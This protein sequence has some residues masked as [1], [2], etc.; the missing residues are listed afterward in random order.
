A[1]AENI[2]SKSYM[3]GLSLL[4]EALSEPD[5]FGPA[6]LERFA[7]S[8]VPTGVAEVARFND[9]V[10]RQSHDIVT[11]M[12]RRLPGYSSDLPPRLDLWG[13][14]IRYESGFGRGYD[15]VSPL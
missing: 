1:I 10:M 2:T 4:M 14:E 7:S 15:A 13:R 9:P 8:F 11:A 3:Q 5:R 12:K 6:Y